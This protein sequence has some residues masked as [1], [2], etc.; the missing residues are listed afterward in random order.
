[1]D[2]AKNYGDLTP[3]I[4]AYRVLQIFTTLLLWP[5][6]TCSTILTGITYGQNVV[7]DLPRATRLRLMRTVNPRKQAD[8][9]DERLMR[10]FNP[11]KQANK[12]DDVHWS[13]CQCTNLLARTS[14]L[15]RHGRGGMGGIYLP[16]DLHTF[17]QN[18][19]G[20]MA[21]FST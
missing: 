18:W 17:G 12:T 11:R 19:L 7:F 6:A 20:G 3:D 9:T 15:P 5:I 2:V 21:I 8:K 1:V 10:T 14:H 13:H 4:K 16:K